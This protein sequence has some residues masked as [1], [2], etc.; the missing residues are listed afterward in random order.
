MQNYDGGI[1]QIPAQH[2]EDL[3]QSRALRP[4]EILVDQRKIIKPSARLDLLHSRIEIIGLRLSLL[5]PPNL[6]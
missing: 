3:G 4:K 5:H 1:S 6:L 2:P